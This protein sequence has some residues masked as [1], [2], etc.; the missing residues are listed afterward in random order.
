MSTYEFNYKAGRPYQG[1]TNNGEKKAPVITQSITAETYAE[2]KKEFWN[3]H[4]GEEI[5]FL[6]SVKVSE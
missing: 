3:E 5:F 1:Y 2:A 6:N 4:D